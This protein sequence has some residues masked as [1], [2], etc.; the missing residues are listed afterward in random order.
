MP[1]SPYDYGSIFDSVFNTDPQ[2][3]LAN[4]YDYGSI[5]DSVFGS[6]ESQDGDWVTQGIFEVNKTT[7]ETRLKDKPGQLGGIGGTARADLEKHISIPDNAE[8]P[9]LN[10]SYKDSGILPG[11]GLPGLLFP[12][13]VE[14]LP[15]GEYIGQLGAAATAG[16]MMAPEMATSAAGAILRTNEWAVK[17]GLKL[18][19][20]PEEALTNVEEAYAPV[21]AGLSTVNDWIGA[22]RQLVLEPG[23]SGYASDAVDSL[24]DLWKDPTFASAAS[25]AKDVPLAVAEQVAQMEAGFFAGGAL[26]GA[27]GAAT[28]AKLIAS[29]IG[30]GYGAQIGTDTY[31]E[32]YDAGISP[33]I[34]GPVA[35]ASGFTQSWLETWGAM[36]MLGGKVIGEKVLSKMNAG[37]VSRTLVRAFTS[38]MT[39]GGEEAAQQVVDNIAKQ[40]PVNWD[41]LPEK[42]LTDLLKAAGNGAWDSF[43]GGAII[44]GPLGGITGLA[45]IEKE[46]KPKPTPTPETVPGV[47]N[48]G[49]VTLDQET[50]DFIAG[51]TPGQVLAA[52]ELGNRIAEDTVAR[53]D[54]DLPSLL[55]N[56]NKE[57]LLAQEDPNAVTRNRTAKA[58]SDRIDETLKLIEAGEA[59]GLPAEQ[60][61]SLFDAL[62]SMS[63][64]SKARAKWAE[65]V[66]KK[67]FDAAESQA[68]A[69]APQITEEQADSL[70][71]ALQTT[72]QKTGESTKQQVLQVG[73][74][75]TT[76]LQ[77]LQPID[78]AA[79]QAQG[80]DPAQL[81]QL[82]GMDQDKQALAAEALAA[83]KRRLTDGD[84]A[85]IGLDS[86]LIENL[87]KVDWEYVA[88]GVGRKA[89][90]AVTEVVEPV[91]T[92]L[93]SSTTSKVLALAAG[94]H[95]K[96]RELSSKVLS[97]AFP[98]FAS[99][100]TDV[101]AEVERVFTEMAK[102]YQPD[103]KVAYLAALS[104]AFGF[105]QFAPDQATI[106]WAKGKSKDQLLGEITA[107]LQQRGFSPESIQNIGSE[108]ELMALSTRSMATVGRVLPMNRGNFILAASEAA[109][110][111]MQSQP[112]A[113]KPYSEALAQQYA[114]QLTEELVRSGNEKTPKY[115][116][117]LTDDV[118]D[119][120]SMLTG[121]S[122]IKTEK[123]QA[124]GV[125]ALGTL[126][127]D[128]LLLDGT[129]GVKAL[130]ALSRIGAFDKITEVVETGTPQ[131]Q[132]R[133]RFASY[134]YE[135]LTGRRP[136]TQD[137]ANQVL[138]NVVWGLSMV[139]G[140]HSL[141]G[142]L[143]DASPDLRVATI[144][145][146]DAMADTWVSAAQGRQK[147]QFYSRMAD[148]FQNFTAPGKVWGGYSHKK[149]NRPGEVEQS[150]ARM[151]SVGWGEYSNFGSAMVGIF[152]HPDSGRRAYTVLHEVIHA[153]DDSG[154]L[155]EMGAGA[156]GPDTDIVG[157]R[158]GVPKERL[159]V[160]FGVFLA[161]RAAPNKKLAPLFH[162]MKRYISS[163]TKTVMDMTPEALESMKEYQE[164]GVKYHPSAINL[165]LVRAFYAML[166]APN[167]SEEALEALGP[168]NVAV[169]TVEDAVQQVSGGTRSIM[170]AFVEGA[171][172]IREDVENLIGDR[173]ESVVYGLEP[174]DDSPN[175]Q[176][177]DA[178]N[179]VSPDIKEHVENLQKEYEATNPMFTV[180]DKKKKEAKSNRP[181]RTKRKSGGRK[182][183]RLK[184]PSVKK[185]QAVIDKLANMEDAGRFTGE[186]S[187]VVKAGVEALDMIDD[188]F[189]QSDKE[190]DTKRSMTWK[191][192]PDVM[193]EK[194]VNWFRM[195]TTRF[196]SKDSRGQRV[197]DETGRA[198]AAQN[199]QNLAGLANRASKVTKLPVTVFD[200]EANQDVPVRTKTDPLD[201]IVNNLQEAIRPFSEVSKIPMENIF[202]HFI[203]YL[204]ANRQDEV[205]QNGIARLQAWQQAMDK[206]EKG[207]KKGPQPE[208]PDIVLSPEFQTAAEQSL[209]LLRMVYG[210]E[211]LK[212]FDT[213]AEQITRWGRAAILDKLLH[214][215]LIS[216]V[217]YDSMVKAGKRWI[218]FTRLTEFID[219]EHIPYEFRSD[220]SVMDPVKFLTMDISGG[221]RNPITELARRAAAVDMLTAK[222]AVRNHLGEMVSS[223]P[224]SHKLEGGMRVIHKRVVV[225]KAV[226]DATPEDIRVKEPRSVKLSDE[227][228][229]RVAGSDPSITSKRV[230]EIYVPIT[231][232]DYGKMQLKGKINGYVVAAWK[233]GVPTYIQITDK[234]LAQAYIEMTPVQSNVWHKFLNGWAFMTRQFVGR[235]L[236]T[237]VSFM[238]NGP[239]RDL[240]SAF[241]RSQHGMLPLIDFGIGLYQSLGV[242]FPTLSE[243][244]PTHFAAAKAY[245]EGRGGMSTM[246]AQ[247]HEVAYGELAHIFRHGKRIRQPKTVTG[248]PGTHAKAIFNAVLG[249]MTDRLYERGVFRSTGNQIIDTKDTQGFK[250]KLVKAGE[251]LKRASGKAKLRR[252]GETIMVPWNG[253][254]FLPELV[255]E[256]MELS[257]RLG[258]GRLTMAEAIQDPRLV[259][260][261]QARN[262]NFKKGD[263]VGYTGVINRLKWLKNKNQIIKSLNEDPYYV[264]PEDSMPVYITGGERD[265]AIRN[266]TLDFGSRGRY[267]STSGAPAAFDGQAL[268]KMY[269][270][271]NPM[272]QDAYSS[273]KMMRPAMEWMYWKASA[274]VSKMLS[275]VEIPQ[276]EIPTHLVKKGLAFMTKMFVGT[277]IPFLAQLLM[278]KDDDD[279]WS[280]SY[281]ER[282]AYIHFPWKNDK[283]QFF[284]IPAGLSFATLIFRDLPMSAMMQAA[285]KDPQ[286]V[287][288]FLDRFFDQMPFGLPFRSAKVFHDKDAITA[289]KQLAYDLAPSFAIQPAISAAMNYNGFFGSE[290]VRP[291]MY[292]ETLAT[293][294]DADR[295]GYV[296]NK[297]ARWMKI[298]PQM[299]DYIIRRGFPGAV[300]LPIA[301][302]NVAN[303]V[304][305]QANVGGEEM[306]AHVGTAMSYGGNMTPWLSKEQWGA[307]NEWVRDFN[308]LYR[309]TQKAR[310][311]YDT[312]VEDGNEK[313]ANE[314]YREYP[315]IQDQN[316]ARL[317]YVNDT[318]RDFWE[319]RK[320][321]TG[322][323]TI[324]QDEKDALVLVHADMPMSL[325]AMEEMRAILNYASEVK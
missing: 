324:P 245:N 317:E 284:K 71:K 55:D 177:G 307:S 285:E 70:G 22:G 136:I 211:N 94:A 107:A 293:E 160:G 18:L 77:A 8:A 169:A 181:T 166:N 170:P 173:D 72:V 125:L 129:R 201:E 130:I 228:R 254:L 296:Q 231:K 200:N 112:E 51:E 161:T 163:Y 270:F 58:I 172:Q 122:N 247:M 121:Y 266:I 142:N 298:E 227:E 184:K 17:E 103:S 156:Y 305:K 87:D 150:N 75:I 302:V 291:E 54:G 60:M 111:L 93:A 257:Y 303:Y 147:A 194:I 190:V 288:K 6:G 79:A 1:D 80:M 20:A 238:W 82:Q 139:P 12:K 86:Y 155:R 66:R 7:G 209:K 223:M 45:G 148:R 168:T 135:R 52:G 11:L 165:G 280:K 259:G 162:A 109:L 185:A 187:S 179:L 272:M 267:A 47:A 198:K 154:L 282:V 83:F 221:I 236:V 120:V 176:V 275:G 229:A 251:D 21:N 5:F 127:L 300:N 226:W 203:I 59:N 319:I 15:G 67:L 37:L 167:V 56:I 178:K 240:F 128:K 308:K 297:L 153:L 50:K 88:E 220:G 310:N 239:W 186:E 174:K 189:I 73:Q 27:S 292:E 57:I 14:S 252:A 63:S 36:E 299:A 95:R 134:I 196:H 269:V 124:S 137:V 261:Y 132:V 9:D 98:S 283:G 222:Q 164:Y 106:D 159:T 311:S 34:A 312:Y 33:L 104:H 99:T 61:A 255:T 212:I 278:F 62:D 123:Q 48:G 253:F 35:A 175:N 105:Q 28:G 301:P 321:I 315:M 277:T 287:S 217:E 117:M 216:Q 279:W 202:K 213:Y 144:A 46:T 232:A 29:N 244:Y 208:K 145:A 113:V 69:S 158:D 215:G 97:A 89:Q 138:Q 131:E 140:P 265:N 23:S 316:W 53:D 85:W 249:D 41:K 204:S 258:E 43:L 108:L 25:F 65:G 40:L 294:R 188:L 262:A 182:R 76:T 141:I 320:E 126:A 110:K 246:Q 318:I 78:V 118:Q 289:G 273:M 30:A 304:A 39:E 219:N 205:F 102:G 31:N 143:R 256:A 323:Q 192:F 233:N 10:I 183:T 290:I 237:T 242:L 101:V 4:P 146:V 81:E 325:F 199:L 151:R 191:N 180:V 276:P 149:S 44:G 157:L 133:S 13:A 214:V 210:D 225:S 206:W 263:R 260:Y 32:L 241:S 234:D 84:L 49:V 64:F 114:E 92:E 115:H 119:P 2:P 100:E 152:S 295:F 218:P 314:L 286:A 74:E 24:K 171:E 195:M 224:N 96:T 274:G 42:S 243:L 90:E 3:S 309:E 322:N 193:G 248:G 250:N 116:E 197:F 271:W 230:Y 207:D 68:R 313:R 264:P 235:P 16:A 281:L 38:A 91:A 268:S 19:D 306:G 26:K